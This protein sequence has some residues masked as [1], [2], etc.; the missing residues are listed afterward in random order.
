MKFTIYKSDD[1]QYYYVVSSRNGQ[2][3]LTSETMKKKQSCTSAIKRIM[4][5]AAE[6]KVD[7]RSL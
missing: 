5:H 3:M 7:D 4:E 6:S 2:I 1:G